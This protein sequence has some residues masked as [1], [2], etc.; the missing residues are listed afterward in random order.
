MCVGTLVLASVLAAC[1]DRTPS[2]FHPSGHAP[3]GDLATPAASGGTTSA[4]PTGATPQ[5]ALAAYRHYQQVYEQIYQT[6]DIAPLRAVAMDPQLSAVAKDVSDVRGQGVIWRFHNTLNPKIQ[7]QARDGLTVVVLDCVQTLGAYR[8]SAKTGKR[9]GAW[10]GGTYLY[11][12]IMKF[13]NGSW[14]I[15]D[16]RQGGKC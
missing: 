10:R 13:D 4:G 12:A 2:G 16:G 6:G 9:L 5:S 1:G 8:F 11:Q 14:K 15:S 7:G 3:S